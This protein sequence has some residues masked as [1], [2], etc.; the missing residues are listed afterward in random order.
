MRIRGLGF[1]P[2]LTHR[3]VA[4]GQF[5]RRTSN[6]VLVTPVRLDADDATI[7]HGR[8]IR[9]VTGARGGVSMVIH[10]S[11]ANGEDP[12]GWT[13]GEREDYAGW[14]SDRQRQWRDGN[15]FA[16]EGFA[17]FKEKFG[18]DAFTLHHRFY[19]HRDAR[20]GWW[21]SAEDGCEGVAE[22][23]KPRG[24]DFGGGASIFGR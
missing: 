7:F 22:E 20:G 8:E 24:R 1:P 10:L 19:L 11:L 9:G 23:A 12:E 17:G 5:L 4:A 14:L 2:Q 3:R 18:E 15:V 6:C 13:S 21:L 16:E